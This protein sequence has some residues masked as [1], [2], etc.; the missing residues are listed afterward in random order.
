M[1]RRSGKSRRKFRSGS[2]WSKP[3][4]HTSRRFHFAG[5]DVSPRIRAWSRNQL[6]VLA[7]FLSK[8]LLAQRPRLPNSSSDS[9]DETGSTV[10]ENF[11]PRT[12]AFTRFLCRASRCGPPH[13][14]Q[15]AR[16]KTRSARKRPIGCDVS[17]FDFEVWP[18]R[19][20]RKLRYAFG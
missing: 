19:S 13:R 14:D 4:V 11:A 1:A 2:S 10:R 17:D 6:P 16:T 12:R 7:E 8:K 18:E 15:R 9:S 5:K 20:T 3:I